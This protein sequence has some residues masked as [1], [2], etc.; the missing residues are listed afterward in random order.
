MAEGSDAEKTEDPTA[1]RQED[2]RKKGQIARSKELGTTGVLVASAASLLMFG[3]GLAI[4]LMDDMRSKFALDRDD[5]FDPKK[6]F[7][8]MGESLSAVS[9]PMFAIFAFILFAAFVA[10]SLLG[11]INF[12]WQAMAPKLNKMSP[13]KGFK[14][15]FGSQALVELVKSIL[16][17]IVVA[18]V[19]IML[20]KIYIRDILF[21]SVQDLPGNTQ[22]ATLLLAWVFMGLCCSTIVIAIIDV[23]FQIWNHSKQLKMSKQEVKDEYKSTEGN[24]EIKGRIRQVQ[25]E[26]SQRRM[27]KDVPDAD[28]VVTNPTHYSVAIKYD[29]T[30]SSSPYIV[31]K[32]ADLMAMQIRKIAK[33][34]DVPIVITPLLTRSIYYTT[35]LNQEIPEQL[36]VAVAQVLAYVYQLDLYN[37]GKGSKPKDLSRNLPI[38]PELRH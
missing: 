30:K 32:G 4:A 31:A 38:P 28:V 21:L 7:Q 13:A 14:R 6:M 29:I 33:E 19:A 12:S 26:I 2:A 25:H 11:G 9:M 34:K 27:M 37:K 36:F 10:N 16:K 20:I 8:A 18:F 23:P 17:V 24:P 15:M 35:E 22:E 1:K 5:I 3:S